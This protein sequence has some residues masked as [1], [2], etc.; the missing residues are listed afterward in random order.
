MIGVPLLQLGSGLPLLQLGWLPVEPLVALA[1]VLLVG[2]VAGS[3][4]PVVPSGL[5]SLA[6][7][8]C[9]WYATGYADPGLL[10]LSGLTLLA[11]LAVA[12]DWLAGAISARAG[13]ASTRTT[14]IA[15]FVGLAALPFGGPVG[16]LLGT[17]G[18]VFV[19]TYEE[20]G[21]VEE[22]LRTAGT[23]LLGMLASNVFQLLLTGSILVGMVLVHVL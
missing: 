11:L 15:T 23:T 17:A 9:Y 1:F 16:F 6:G 12:V 21:D 8:Y 3:V 4:L 18:T 2:G 5:L 13:G 10:A 20:D 19:L 22:S 7:V 14:V